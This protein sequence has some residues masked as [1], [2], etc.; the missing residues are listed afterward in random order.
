MRNMVQKMEITVAL[1]TEYLKWRNSIS[2]HLYSEVMTT[3]YQNL[4]SGSLR[5]K[6]LNSSSFFMGRAGPSSI[7]LA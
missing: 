1:V 5:I 3:I 7:S 6:G 2:M 4:N